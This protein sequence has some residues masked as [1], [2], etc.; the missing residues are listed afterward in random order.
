MEAQE[1]ARVIPRYGTPW[2]LHVN[3]SFSEMFCLVSVGTP[4]LS[5]RDLEKLT[6]YSNMIW[7]KM[8]L[9][10]GVPGVMILLGWLEGG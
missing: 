9:R 8:T 1:A 7:N 5:I 2:E 10:F 3:G 4:R 6:L